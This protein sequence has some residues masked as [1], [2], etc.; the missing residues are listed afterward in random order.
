M[1]KKRKNI[2]RRVKQT[3]GEGSVRRRGRSNMQLVD[4][5]QR[6]SND[7]LRNNQSTDRNN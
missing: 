1:P 2:R 6:T 7:R 5:M 4:Q 3:L